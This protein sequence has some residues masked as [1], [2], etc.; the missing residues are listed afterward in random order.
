EILVPPPN[1]SNLRPFLKVEIEDFDFD[2][3]YIIDKDKRRARI[4]KKKNK[5]SKVAY[6]YDE[7]GNAYLKEE[8]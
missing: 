3:Y 8:N 1:V 6:C 4:K 2:A 5:P 7:A